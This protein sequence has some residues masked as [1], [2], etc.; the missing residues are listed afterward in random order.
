[1]K[2]SI[3]LLLVYSSVNAQQTPQ[4]KLKEFH[5]FVKL[6]MQRNFIMT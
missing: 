3:F 6:K 5:L 1:M 4:Q 2:I